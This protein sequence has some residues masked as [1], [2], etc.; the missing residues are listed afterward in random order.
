MIAIG[1]ADSIVK[2]WSLT[3]SKLREMKTAEQLKD[4]DRDAGKLTGYIIFFFWDLI[5][6]IFRRCPCSNDGRSNG[7]DVSNVSRPQRTHLPMCI[8]AGSV[9]GVVVLGGHHHSFVVAANDDV[10]G[11][12][13]FVS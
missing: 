2:V 4:I 11:T 8:L 3:P 7:R 12:I 9:D 6:F 10:C 1:F 5:C 13:F